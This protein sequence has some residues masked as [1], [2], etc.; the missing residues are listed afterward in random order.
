MAAN[1]WSSTA[2]TNSRTAAKSTPQYLPARPTLKTQVARLRNLPLQR[3][4]FLL[5]PLASPSPSNPAAAQGS[6]NEPFT[7]VYSAAGRDHSPDGRD[8]S[9]RH[10]RLPAAA[11]FRTATSRLS[12]HSSSDLLSRC[13]PRCD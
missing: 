8:H 12:H 7:A 5:L 3:L 6:E 1:S 2:R 11:S 4:A 13:Q 9:G 10:R